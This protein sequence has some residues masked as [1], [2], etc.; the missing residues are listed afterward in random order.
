M[1]RAALALTDSAAERAQLRRRLAVV[2][3]AVGPGADVR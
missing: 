1:Y 3:A 2:S